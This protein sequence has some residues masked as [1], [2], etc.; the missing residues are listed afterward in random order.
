MLFFQVSENA[1][2]EICPSASNEPDFGTPFL[3]HYLN[4][5]YKSVNQ[6]RALANQFF[7][8]AQYGVPGNSDAG[9]LNSWLIWQ[10][11]GLYPIVTQPIYLLGSPWFPDINVTINENKN[12]RILSYGAGDPAA[13]GQAEYFVQRVAINGQAWTKNWFSHE[14]IMVGGG[15][16]EFWVGEN[17]TQV[18]KVSANHIHS[19][20]VLQEVYCNLV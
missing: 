9:A 15:T 19:C 7:H 8:D 16:I 12:L 3:Y 20:K 13:L 1:I 14:D 6:T 5:Q 2:N 10:M 4:K 17:A 18:S 11:L